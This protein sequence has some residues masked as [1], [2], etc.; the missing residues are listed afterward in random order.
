MLKQQVVQVVATLLETVKAK[1]KQTLILYKR[2]DSRACVIIDLHFSLPFSFQRF[3]SHAHYSV[4]LLTKYISHC[5]SLPGEYICVF[6]VANR[7][8]Q[9]TRISLGEFCCVMKRYISVI[10]M[11]GQRKPS[12][13]INVTSWSA[14]GFNPGTSWML[15]NE[16]RWN[17]IIEQADLKILIK[18]LRFYSPKSY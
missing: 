16:Q 9:P 14:S 10:W 13:N 11:N 4:L 12:S 15:L 5:F 18:E 8:I 3:G 1:L 2:I 17:Y 7:H 6:T